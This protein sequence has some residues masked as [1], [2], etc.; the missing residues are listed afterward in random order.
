LEVPN[1]AYWP[2][3]T[4]LMLGRTPLPHVEDIYLSDEPFIGHHHEFTMTEL[5]ELARL[6]GLEVTAEEYFNYTLNRTN[7]FKLFIRHPIMSTAFVLRE[8]TRE[9]IAVLCKRLDP[10]PI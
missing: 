4:A 7:P 8:R 3:R 9:C 1:I 2:K 5:H 10:L 6:A